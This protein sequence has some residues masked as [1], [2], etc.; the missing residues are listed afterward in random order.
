MSLSL[1]ID[2]APQLTTQHPTF[3]ASLEAVL[4]ASAGP[5]V[6]YRVHSLAG[7]PTSFKSVTWR[8]INSTMAMLWLEADDVLPYINRASHDSGALS[9]FISVFRSAHAQHLL[10][11]ETRVVIYKLQLAHP[12]LVT[13]VESAFTVFASRLNTQVFFVDTIDAA[14]ASVNEAC[15]G[16]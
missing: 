6:G 2:L 1:D 15:D 13:A 7:S 9:N 14:A 11:D 8:D 5:N 4:A 10:Q 12:A 3:C 16:M